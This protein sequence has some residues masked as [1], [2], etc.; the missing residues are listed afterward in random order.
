MPLVPRIR[1][2]L[3]PSSLRAEV[4]RSHWNRN[5][6]V[7]TA[8]VAALALAVSLFTWL[9][10]RKQ[11]SLT[12]GQVRAYLQ[13]VEAELSEPMRLGGYVKVKL[14]LKNLGQT[15]A[16]RVV[17]DFDHRLG[18]PGD[19][20]SPNYGARRKLQSFGPGLERQITLTSN[21]M[22]RFALPPPQFRL[23]PVMYF[24][25]TV[26]FTDDTTQETR[27]EDWCYSLKFVTEQDLSKTD[28]EPCDI[29][30]YKSEYNAPE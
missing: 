21:R 19:G 4:N 12:S 6:E 5:P 1:R 9:D 28:L 15:A 11:L 8:V 26:W 14:K 29:L 3:K 22:E 20:G 10:T 16:V 18:T 23:P 24:F 17:A 25:G 7:W 27:K 13:V 30:T 2:R